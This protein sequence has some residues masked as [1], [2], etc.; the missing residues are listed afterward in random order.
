[1]GF[2]YLLFV[3]DLFTGLSR[4][5]SGAGMFDPE[6]VRLF[7]QEQVDVRRIRETS[8]HFS[9]YAHMAGTEGDYALAIDTRNA[10][11]DAGLEQVT[12]DEFYVYLNYPRADGRTVQIME[13]SSGD[14]SSLR[15]I[16]TADLEELDVG[17][18][19]AGHEPYVFHGLSRSGEVLA[20][21]VYARYGSEADF[22]QL[23]LLGVDVRGTIALMRYYGDPSDRAAKVLNA[24]RAGCVGALIYSDPADDGFLRGPVAPGGRFMPADGVQRGS[25]ALTSLVVGDVLTPGWESTKGM[26]RMTTKDNP[27]LVNIPSLPL[28]WRDAKVILQHI[29]GFGA[30]V[31]DNSGE[32]SV[33]MSGGTSAPSVQGWVG[34]VPDVGEWWTGNLSG[35]VVRLRNDNDEVDQQP[36]WNVYGKIPGVEQ[37]HHPVIVGAHRDA[38]SFGASDPGSGTSVMLELVR[39]FGSLMDHGWRPLRP[40]EFMSWDAEEYNLIGSTEFVEK[41]VDLLRGNALAYINLDSVVEGDSLRAAGSPVFRRMLL[42]ALDRVADLNFNTTLRELWDRRG[43]RLDALGASSDYVAFQDIAGTSSL[44]L[45]F[46]P[47]DG[48]PGYP[49]HSSYDNFDW[50][51]RVG[52]PGFAYHGMVAQV[53]ALLVLELADR[54]V[55][56]FDMP[57]YADALARWVA[58]LEQWTGQRGREGIKEGETAFEGYGKLKTAVETVAAAVREFV[59]WE[60]RWETTVL[61]NNHWEGLGLG[62]ERAEYN[63]RMG[64]FETNLLD[65][66]VGGGVSILTYVVTTML[67]VADIHVDPEP[68]PI[69]AHPLRPIHHQRLRWHHL[70]CHPRRHHCRQLDPRQHPCGQVGAAAGA[71]GRCASGMNGIIVVTDIRAGPCPASYV[72]T[73]CHLYLNRS[74]RNRRMG[75]PIVRRL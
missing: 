11:L 75:P 57:A 31:P 20:P 49:Y 23:R 18:E 45:S 71:G 19:T 62:R 39:V 59:Q 16:W 73:G 32:Q 8:K 2:V 63:K 22:E 64:M 40:I 14:P 72:R 1:M 51:D 43:G 48:R 67:L 25:V 7:V 38:W 29:R 5:M 53:V 10:F 65:L 69:Q 24:E 61:A 17:V 27:G 34:G 9:S 56:P 3:S 26:P 30:K 42:R 52:D 12:V 55:L 54:P 68:D 46:Q 13:K 4:K 50:M 47:A 37:P 35:P 15:P 58:E 28:A 44:D 36:I 70:P 21:V 60:V 33:H 41:N 66:E 6:A 74:L